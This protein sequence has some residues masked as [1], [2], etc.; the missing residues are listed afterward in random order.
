MDEGGRE[1]GYGVKERGYPYLELDAS[2]A[3]VVS[4]SLGGKKRMVAQATFF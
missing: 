3:L 1:G 2:A 4:E